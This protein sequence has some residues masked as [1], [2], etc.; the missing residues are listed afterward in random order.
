[1]MVVSYVLSEDPAVL[2]EQRKMNLAKADLVD[3]CYSCFGGDLT[4]QVDGVDFSIATGG[5]VQILD[6]AVEFFTVGRSVAT[7]N[8][9]RIEFAGMADEIYVTLS[10]ESVKVSSNYTEEIAQVT[11]Q[12]FIQ[13]G[14]TFLTKVLTD[15]ATQYPELKSNR[16]IKK[17]GS[18]V[19]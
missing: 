11:Q 17:A 3:L 2:R 13:A 15:L 12:Q 8:S 7:G 16:G 1:M 14:R 9:G 5:G 4:L 18:W 10:G 19:A 6:F